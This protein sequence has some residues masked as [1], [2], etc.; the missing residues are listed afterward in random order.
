MQKKKILFDWYI[1]DIFDYL[2]FQKNLI[3]FAQHLFY[4]YVYII[5]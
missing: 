3:H 4:I 1:F 2:K 5:N